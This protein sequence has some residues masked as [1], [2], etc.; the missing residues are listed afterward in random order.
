MTA[1]SMSFFNTEEICLQCKRDERQAPGFAGAR[2]ADDAAI[3]RGNYTFPGLGLP[4]AD[5]AFL[6]D[7]V[8]KRRGRELERLA[9]VDAARVHRPSAS[10][11]TIK[12][13]GCLNERA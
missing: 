4:E 10:T 1:H 12:E 5:H 11:N 3:K 9:T 2:A 8:A 6:A 13:K 7:L